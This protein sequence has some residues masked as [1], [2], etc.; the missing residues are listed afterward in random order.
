MIEFKQVMKG[1]FNDVIQD[2]HCCDCLQEIVTTLLL[3]KRLPSNYDDFIRILEDKFPLGFLFVSFGCV[4]VLICKNSFK[5]LQLVKEELP[6]LKRSCLTDYIIVDGETVV[7]CIVCLI[8]IIVKKKNFLK[9]F[10]LA[11]EY[12]QT[13]KYSH[14]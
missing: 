9:H 1:V 10:R 6:L 5:F 8:K 4:S 7:I 3:F 2:V 12:R 11:D 14:L 13:A